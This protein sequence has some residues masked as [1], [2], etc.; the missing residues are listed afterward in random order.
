MRPG[1]ARDMSNRVLR[2]S[3]DQCPFGYLRGHA[4]GDCTLPLRALVDGEPGRR[5]PA[6]TGVDDFF[7][8]TWTEP[9]KG[10]LNIDMSQLAIR[11]AGAPGGM[12]EGTMTM[13]TMFGDLNIEPSARDAEAV[14]DLDKKLSDLRTFARAAL[15]LAPEELATIEA[16]L[17]TVHTTASGAIVRRM[18]Q[19][20]RDRKSESERKK[21]ARYDARNKKRR[22]ALW[23]VQPRPLLEVVG[24]NGS[25]PQPSETPS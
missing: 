12:Q 20:A 15:A 5:A 16:A 10:R 8:R 17:T 22:E 6:S 1:T 14:V 18:V 11:R 4:S 7:V 21:R 23:Q 25:C 19:E 24:S 2:S 9:R 3:F 13:K